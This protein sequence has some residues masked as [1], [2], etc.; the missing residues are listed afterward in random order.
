MTNLEQKDPQE[1]DYKNIVARQ[2]LYKQTES[3]ARKLAFPAYRANVVSYTF[4][5]ISYRTLNR[6]DLSKIW[7]T[8]ALPGDHFHNYRVDAK[9]VR[10]DCGER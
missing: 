6:I 3:I 2:I 9:S 1:I 5:L 8:Q 10:Y 7:A 4:A